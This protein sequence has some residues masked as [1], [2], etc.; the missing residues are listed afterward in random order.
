MPKLPDEITYSDKYED[1]LFEYQNITLPL[2]IYQKMK[3][4]CLLSQ[5]D[6]K[7]LG[8]RKLTGWEHYYIYKKEPFVLLLRRP[9]GY[10]P[11]TGEIPREIKEKLEDRKTVM[12]IEYNI[13]KLLY[14]EDEIIPENF[15]LNN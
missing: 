9:L 3:K 13:A 14:P 10:N 7:Q 2:E 1:D 12:E 6:L 4:N 11:F 8:F 15:C 5:G